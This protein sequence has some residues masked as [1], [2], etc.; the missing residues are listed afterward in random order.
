MTYMEV[1]KKKGR[2]FWPV[3]GKGGFK[4][5]AVK[6]ARGRGTGINSFKM[7]TLRKSWSPEG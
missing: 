2:G 7:S 6:A 5:A 4:K 1:E 3:K